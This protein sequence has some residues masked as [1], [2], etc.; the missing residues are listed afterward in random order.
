MKIV[1]L[2]NCF[3]ILIFFIALELTGLAERWG[4]SVIPN[5]FR[6]EPSSIE[7]TEIDSEIMMTGLPTTGTLTGIS[8]KNRDQLIEYLQCRELLYGAVEEGKPKLRIVLKDWGG[9]KGAVGDSVVVS[10]A[11]YADIPEN[12]VKA[13]CPKSEFPINECWFIKYTDEQ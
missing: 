10:Y 2:L 8:A 11:T 3:T 7:A 1:I 13:D 4:I 6:S 9:G 5:S 12:S